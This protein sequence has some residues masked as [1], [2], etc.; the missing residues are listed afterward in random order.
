MSFLYRICYYFFPFSVY[1]V[2]MSIVFSSFSFFL[3]FPL[4]IP[5]FLWLNGVIII[6]KFKRQHFFFSSLI[7]PWCFSSALLVVSL[8]GRVIGVIFLHECVSWHLFFTLA[9]YLGYSSSSVKHDGSFSFSCSLYGNV[10]FPSW[11]MLPIFLPS[12]IN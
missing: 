2:T 8:L 9:T 5:F 3:K 4:N 7:F 12:T 6:R 11:H 10:L 1:M